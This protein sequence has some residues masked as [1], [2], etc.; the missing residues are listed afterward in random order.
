MHG[1]CHMQS[2]TYAVLF[3]DKLNIRCA[4]CDKH[5][6]TFIISHVLIEDV[7]A[8]PTLAESIFNGNT[9]EVLDPPC[10]PMAETWGV[11]HNNEDLVIQCG[12]CNKPIIKCKVLG[13]APL[14]TA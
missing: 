8:H 6:V 4:T 1:R 2:R 10:H 9:E 7:D 13:V 12:E 11:L 14:G 5:I 3:G